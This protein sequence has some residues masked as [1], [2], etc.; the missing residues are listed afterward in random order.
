[1]A[2]RQELGVQNPKL[3]AVTRLLG[4]ERSPGDLEVTPLGSDI[5]F[6]CCP[7]VAKALAKEGFGSGTLEGMAFQVCTADLEDE[8]IRRLCVDVVLEVIADQGE[9]HRLS[10]SNAS[11]RCGAYLWK[12]SCGGSLTDEAATRS[13]TRP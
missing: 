5:L 1:M 3:G 6:L 8:L 11:S 10:F 7:R 9:L 13:G 4:G 12:H 2:F